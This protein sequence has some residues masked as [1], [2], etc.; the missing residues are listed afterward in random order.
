MAAALAE[1]PRAIVL[2]SK[3]VADQFL[4]KKTPHF[5]RVGTSADFELPD[6]L[7][8]STELWVLPSTSA[9]APMPWERRIA[10][11]KEFTSTMETWP[12]E[13]VS[14]D[15]GPAPDPAGPVNGESA[16]RHQHD[17]RESRVT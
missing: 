14:D 1:P 10:P 13:A 15:A 2:V 3:T 4:R 7:G 17:S 11:F 8:D 16:E 9:R 5:G 6:W 12:W